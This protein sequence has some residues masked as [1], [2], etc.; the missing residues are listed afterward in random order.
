MSRLIP[1]LLIAVC[2]SP[3]LRAQDAPAREIRIIKGLTYRDDSPEAVKA[4]QLDL[5]IPANEDF[6][7]IIWFHG[8]GLTSGTRQLPAGLTH[9]GIAVVGVD[10]RLYPNVSVAG[11]IEDAAASIAWTFANIQTYGGDPEKIFVS[12]HSA[13]GYLTSMTGLDESYLAKYDLSPDRLAGLIPLSGHTITHFTERKSRGL[14]NTDVVV[15]EMAPLA[16]LNP[17]APPM[18]LVTGG[19]EHELL[20]RYEENA[21]FYRMMKVVGHD[22]ITLYELDGHNHTGMVAASLPLVV[23]WVRRHA[24]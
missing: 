13:G 16:H 23:K 17:K 12:G 9:Q 19:R 20:G 1:L 15:D 5:F 14:G 4:C 21:Y 10:Y 7:T 22:N 24:K 18:L 2:L 11:C 6:A 8:G 3:S